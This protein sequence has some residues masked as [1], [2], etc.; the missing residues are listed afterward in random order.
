MLVSA[1]F[2][3]PTLN[4]ET[5]YIKFTLRFVKVLENYLFIGDIYI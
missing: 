4:K 2:T 1:S 5:I 3:L